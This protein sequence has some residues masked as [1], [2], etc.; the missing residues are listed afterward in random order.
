[1]FQNLFCSRGR[2]VSSGRL[3]ASFTTSMPASC[4]EGGVFLLKIK[5]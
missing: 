5:L 4:V 3:A 1:M 2:K